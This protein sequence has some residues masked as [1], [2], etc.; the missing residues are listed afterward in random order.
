[1][2]HHVMQLLEELLHVPR[3]DLDDVRIEA[4]EPKRA[5]HAIGRQFE[6]LAEPVPDDVARLLRALVPN[7]HVGVRSRLL[8]EQYERAGL[9]P[10]PLAILAVHVH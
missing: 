6:V 3:C 7:D 2:L 4:I 9:R 1:M 8:G 5:P 10:R